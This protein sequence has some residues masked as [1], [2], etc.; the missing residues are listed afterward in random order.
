MRHLV[1]N[2]AFALLLL[3]VLGLSIAGPRLVSAQSV[4]RSP[5]APAVQTA[6]PSA[7]ELTN[8]KDRFGVVL[9][10]VTAPSAI[11]QDQGVAA[12]Q[13]WLG[14]VYAPQA[15]GIRVAHVLL[16]DMIR[17]KKDEQGNSLPANDHTSAWLISFSGMQFPAPGGPLKSPAYFYQDVYVAIDAQ[18]GAF[19]EGWGISR[20][21]A[22]AVK[23]VWPDGSPLCSPS[24]TS[25]RP[26]RIHTR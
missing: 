5:A 19:I 3:I 15:T 2:C 4:H 26:S 1:N 7:D 22:L 17:Q 12:A 23:L 10:Q 16:T 8:L 18:T 13:K 21:C 25:P 24:G 6:L 11:T 20:H 14:R 9:A